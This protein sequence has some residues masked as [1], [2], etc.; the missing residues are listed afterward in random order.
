MCELFGFSC[1]KPVGVSFSW[2]G[3]LARGRFNRDSWG[4][5]FYPDMPS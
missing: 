2:R 1:N 3:F 5:T 4:V